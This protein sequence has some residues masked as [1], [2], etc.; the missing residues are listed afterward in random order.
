[1][2]IRFRN[3]RQSYCMLPIICKCRYY[4]SHIHLLNSNVS[5]SHLAILCLSV[6]A[7]QPLPGMAFVTITSAAIMIIEQK[8][9]LALPQT[10]SHCDSVVHLHN[11]PPCPPPTRGSRG[12]R[13]AKQWA[14]WMASTYANLWCVCHRLVLPYENIDFTLCLWGKHH[15]HTLYIV[16]IQTEHWSPA[17]HVHFPQASAALMHFPTMSRLE[18]VYCGDGLLSPVFQGCHRC[19]FGYMLI[20]FKVAVYGSIEQ[21]LSD[22]TAFIDH[23]WSFSTFLALFYP[24]FSVVANEVALWSA[25][26]SDGY[27]GKFHFL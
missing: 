18:C 7:A 4:T 3:T 25:T 9:M 17:C 15:T 26:G 23:N 5:L 21:M 12:D 2:A 1:M 14:R 8:K 22:A 24:T 10:P 19:W 20:F 16:Y 11:V 13:T 27:F 6:G